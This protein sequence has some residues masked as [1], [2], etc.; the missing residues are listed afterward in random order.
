MSKNV[1]VIRRLIWYILLYCPGPAEGSMY[2]PE[3][4][5]ICFYVAVGWAVVRP[6]LPLYPDRRVAFQPPYPGHVVVGPH[7]ARE[8]CAPAPPH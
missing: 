6:E 8:I 5:C 1:L 2:N 3:L 4:F 7:Y